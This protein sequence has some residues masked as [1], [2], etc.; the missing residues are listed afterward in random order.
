MTSSAAIGH[1][2]IDRRFRAALL[3]DRWA[4]AILPS[5]GYPPVS[6]ITR[7]ISAVA[8]IWP[9]SPRQSKDP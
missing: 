4:R 9:A 1:E 7:P 3:T 2:L 5:L 6:A 8:S